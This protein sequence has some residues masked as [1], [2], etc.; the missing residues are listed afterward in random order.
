M[1]LIQNNKKTFLKKRDLKIFDRYENE[2]DELDFGEICL[3]CNDDDEE[4][5][6]WIA[7]AIFYVCSEIIIREVLY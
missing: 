3:S 2:N 6:V 4:R 7:W 5:M 1:V